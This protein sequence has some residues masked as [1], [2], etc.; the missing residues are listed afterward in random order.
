MVAKPLVTLDRRRMSLED[1]GDVVRA[2]RTS[3]NAGG[4]VVV[5]WPLEIDGTEG[6]ACSRV[7]LFGR[8]LE[9]LTK[10]P[11]V[12]WDERF[13]TKS[14]LMAS[15]AARRGDYAPHVRSRSRRSMNTAPLDAHAA[16]LVLQSFLDDAN[17]AA[18]VPRG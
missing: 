9:A 6:T 13:S 18:V 12:Y 8:R 2:L 14:A 17:A 16:A 10:L 4:G 11:L 7:K 1:V 5:G 3:H 15:A